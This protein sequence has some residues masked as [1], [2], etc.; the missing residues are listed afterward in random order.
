MDTFSGPEVV[1]KNLVVGKN[2]TR[3]SVTEKIERL[4]GPLELQRA[5]YY[6]CHQKQNMLIHASSRIPLLKILLLID[7]HLSNLSSSGGCVDSS[8]MPSF[9]TF[10]LLG[11]GLFGFLSLGN[12]ILVETLSIET[13]TTGGHNT[14]PVLYRQTLVTS[15]DVASGS[16]IREEVLHQT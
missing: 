3:L 1:Q 7:I 6:Y 13:Q 12:V 9:K 5:D 16:S 11:I 2:N 10:P 15:A 8:I 4:F 14:Q